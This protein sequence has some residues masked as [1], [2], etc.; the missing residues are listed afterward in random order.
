M[1]P[2]TLSAAQWAG[3]KEAMHAITNVV[4]REALPSA[5]AAAATMATAPACTSDNDFDGRIG[6]RI[7][8]IFVILFGSLFG[9]LSIPSFD[10]FIA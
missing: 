3:G 10:T 9:I 2:G 4:V 8:A 5:S 7:S 1:S 6:L